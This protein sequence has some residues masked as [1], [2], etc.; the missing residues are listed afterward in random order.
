MNT[1]LPYEVFGLIKTN[2]DVHTLGI[3]TIANLL[4]QCGY[5]TI[6]SDEL[7]SGAVEN[8]R[9]INNWGLVK[10]WISENKITRIGF[11][12]RLEPNEGKEYFIELYHQL[13]NDKSFFED[14]GKIRGLFFAGL[15]DACELIK[16]QLKCEIIFFHGGESTHESLMRLGISAEKWPDELLAGCKYDND[17]LDFAK[18]I[19]EKGEYVKELPKNHSS[20]P[21][22]GLR[23]DLLVDRIK[24]TRARGT[25]PLIRAHVGPYHQNREE[26]LKEFIDWTLQLAKSGYLDI[27]SIGTSQLTQSNFNEDWHDLPNGGGVAINSPLD[28]AKIW[29]AARP[30]LVRTYAGT[31]NVPYLASVYEEYLHIAWHALSF[32]W[33]CELDGRGKNSLFENI[34]Q[35]FMT[36][37]YIASLS[38]PLE[39]N[40][41]H[42]FSF[43]GGDDVTYIL[44]AYLTAKLVKRMGIKYF[45]LQNMLN[46]PKSTWGIQDLA[47]SRVLLKIIKELEDNTFRVIFQ[48]RAGLDFFCPDY[49]KAKIQLASVTAL[50][51]DI[52]PTDMNSPEIIHVVGYSEAIRL[53][54]PVVINESIKIT[55]NALDKYRALRRTGKIEDMSQNKDVLFR[56]TELYEETKDAIS[57]LEDKIPYLYTPEGFYKIFMDGFLPVPYLIDNGNKF[58]KARQYQTQT[59]NGSVKI[60]DNKGKP[61]PTGKRF[62]NILGI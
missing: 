9:V 30:M 44:S 10:R 38:K 48:P 7:V 47:K 15:P 31:K 41:P 45:I 46:T 42:H 35:H 14:G 6:I 52:E 11:S 57:L 21:N 36:V 34:K 20:Y 61:I 29:E 19:I 60:V 59:I 55:F 32:W 27:L 22:Y 54:D 2:I 53:A 24:N 37:Q 3:S 4:R 51:D 49:E 33:F 58:P 50:M 23:N 43:R 13:K 8:I 40:V 28:Y 18:A 5:H 26:S 17:R 25:L 12:Y 39:A 56:Y 1:L 62:K 16:Q